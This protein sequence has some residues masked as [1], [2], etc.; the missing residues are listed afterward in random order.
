MICADESYPQNTHGFDVLL[1][2]L[3][4]AATVCKLPE[5]PVA[6]ET[7]TPADVVVVPAA[8]VALVALVAAAPVPTPAA[9]P[10]EHAVLAPA[11]MVAAPEKLQIALNSTHGEQNNQIRITHFCTP[12]LSFTATSKL[13]PVGKSTVL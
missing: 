6:V 8:A 9:E 11:R 2:A 3:A 5:A 12:V 1:A 13:V 10:V 7:A 4:E